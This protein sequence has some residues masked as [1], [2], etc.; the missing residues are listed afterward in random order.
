[1]QPYQGHVE[2]IDA[3]RGIVRAKAGG[4]RQ[5][6]VEIMVNTRSIADLIEKGDVSEI[7]EATD[8]RLSPGSQSF[9]RH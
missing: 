7:K 2:A 5:A 6:A 1:V 8:K 4:R 9:K 3:H